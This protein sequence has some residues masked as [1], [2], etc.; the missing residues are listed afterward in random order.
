MSY[1]DSVRAWNILR[2]KKEFL[3]EF[4][5]LKNRQEQF[6][7]EMLVFYNYE[8]LEKTIKELKNTGKVPPV[9]FWI[10][11]DRTGEKL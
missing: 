11:K 1:N 3:Q 2:L 5:Q 6:S 7:Y 8:E 9:L 4:Q 10:G